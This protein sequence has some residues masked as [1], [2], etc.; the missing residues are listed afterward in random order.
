V[1]SRFALRFECEEGE[2]PQELF[3]GTFQTL[4]VAIDRVAATGHLHRPSFTAQSTSGAELN[5]S[6]TP[7]ALGLDSG[8]TVMLMRV[9][10]PQ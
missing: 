4:G 1:E 5:P 2:F 8:E 6:L 10:S 9:A 3:I 7:T